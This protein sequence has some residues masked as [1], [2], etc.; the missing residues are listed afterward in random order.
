M[1]KWCLCITEEREICEPNFFD[2]YAEA[3]EEM[4]AR[5]VSNIIDNCENDDDLDENNEAINIEEASDNGKFGITPVDPEGECS[6][7]WSNLNE[8]YALDAKIFKV[9]L[10]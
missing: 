3:Y 8:D 10:A 5:L 6:A 2:S 9:T 1:L 4:K 7:M